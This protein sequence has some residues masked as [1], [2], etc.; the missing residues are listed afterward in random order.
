MYFN[1]TSYNAVSGVYVGNTNRKNSSPS[2]LYNGL[3]AAA[4]SVVMMLPAS[5]LE[6]K[7]SDLPNGKPNAGVSR[8]ISDSNMQTGYLTLK[9]PDGEI[10][11]SKKIIPS[12]LQ[13]LGEFATIRLKAGNNY[14]FDID[15]PGEENG[16]VRY[17]AVTSFFRI[18]RKNGKFRLKTTL[19]DANSTHEA[20]IIIEYKNGRKRFF[21]I[22]FAFE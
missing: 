22:K 20:N 13:Y 7:V 21:R 4:L 12:L 9:G 6:A 5:G 19:F 8:E 18:D 14:D 16:K 17:D 15:F 10:I 11:A 1:M 2:R 3:L